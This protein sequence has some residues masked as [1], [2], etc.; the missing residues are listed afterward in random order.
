MFTI[1]REIRIPINPRDPPEVTPI[2]QAARDGNFT[3]LKRLYE[4]EKC[5][6]ISQVIVAAAE[7]GHLDC[8]QYAHRQGCKWDVL[9]LTKSAYNGHL[10][11]LQYALENGCNPLIP[12]IVIALAANGGQLECLKYL[13]EEKHFSWDSE[14]PRN[15]AAAGRLECLKYAHENGCEWNEQTCEVAAAMGHLE[16]LKYAYE[17]GCPF[18][19]NTAKFASDQGELECLK[20]VYEHGGE[21][22]KQ[23]IQF[24]AKKGR[25][26]CLE[27]AL[28][29]GC[30]YD[31]KDVLSAFNNN[32]GKDWFKLDF[33]QYSFL[34]NLLFPHVDTD[35]MNAN[36]NA[37]LYEVCKAQRDEIE[38]QIKYA[39][40]ECDQL[41]INV[42]EF[43]LIKYI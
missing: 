41:P 9:V 21:M 3:E 11:C 18:S 35:V 26:H 2:E 5:E 24:A 1:S 4:E 36:M 43:I 34:R 40:Q 39:Y 28:Q 7:H 8:L 38:L 16:C 31:I 27:Y 22:N 42:I 10:H 30:E 37:E 6:L 17:H 20:Y 32:F 29:V 25:Y 13:R 14:T 23:V 33:Q 12:T 19:V 15:A